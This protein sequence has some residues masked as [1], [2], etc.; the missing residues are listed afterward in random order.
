VSR[1]RIFIRRRDGRIEVRLS[2][3]GR[4]F[5]REWFSR[6]RVAEADA[7]HAWHGSLSP[8]IDP[9]QDADD[10]LRSLERQR[11]VATNAELALLST[12]EDLLSEGEAWAWLSSLQLALRAT[13]ALEGLATA[14]D[15]EHA[16]AN[17]LAEVRALQ[18]LLGELAD[19]L[20]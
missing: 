7:E 15:V 3:D 4:A 2:D 9:G 19:A 5:V 13:A 17:E 10:P 11:A 20:A 14:D 6:L 1:N 8:P 16:T 12:D 18:H